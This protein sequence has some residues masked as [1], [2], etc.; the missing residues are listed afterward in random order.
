MRVLLP[1]SAPVTG[2]VALVVPRWTPKTQVDPQGTPFRSFTLG[3]SFLTA[4]LEVVFFDQE[5]DLD[6]VDR[7]ARFLG[8]LAG[9]SAAF[10]WMNECYPSNQWRNAHALA[11][12]M[13]AHRPD[14]PVVVG[15]EFITLLPPDFLD[16]EHP[17]DFFLQGYGE[18]SSLQLLAHL[19]AGT[20]PDDVPGLVWRD[21]SGTLRHQPPSRS[22]HYPP[23]FQVFYR[24]LNMSFYEQK[25]GVF[26]NGLGTLTVG[27]GRGCVKGCRFC[28][29]RNH[30]SKIVDADAIFD[31]LTYLREETKVRQ[32][33][34][35]EL[36]FFMSHRRALALADR[37]AETGSDIMWYA[38]GS[39]VD[40][41]VFTD[42]EWD[43]LYAGGLRKIEMGSESGSARLLRVIGKQH[44]PD[45]IVNV[46]RKL[47]ERGMIPMNNFLFGFPGETREDRLETLR[48]IDR[49]LSISFERNHITYRHYQPGWLTAM[50]ASC[51]EHAPDAP[52][53]VD[54][55]IDERPRYDDERARTMPWLPTEDERDLKAMINHD[56]PLAT[57]QLVLG[58]KWRR[59]LYHTLRERA[60]RTLRR[61]G[62]VPTGE[63]WL[64]DRL[65]GVQLDRTYVA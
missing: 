61:G 23:N 41:R 12:M 24:K 62:R 52:S 53:R 31:L 51:L 3:A 34:F 2:R 64:Y 54:T 28:T 36:D 45:D 58:S 56:L 57:S 18:R 7:R 50:G 9:C 42:D 55:W 15:G 4:G 17:A 44:E 33:H 48:V 13:K 32:Y 65:I 6:R 21:A 40:L 20:V 39:P 10:I 22:A 37:I 25:G 59:W 46:S 8:E 19:D 30:P 29:W 14:M 16:I 35:G 43:R 38:L 1:E 60:Q 63:R 5:H 11:A 27:T 47:L 49:L 26:G